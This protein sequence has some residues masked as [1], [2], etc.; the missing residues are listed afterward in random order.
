MTARP[1]TTGKDE[2]MSITT[3]RSAFLALTVA[4]SAG[5]H[6]ALVPEHLEEMPRLGY[7]F[8]VAAVTGGLLACGLVL[9]SHDRRVAF[10]AGLF[11]LG[12]ISAWALFVSIPVPGF[13]G[14]PEPVEAIAL[15]CKAVEVVGVVVALSLAAPQRGRLRLSPA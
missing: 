5:L 3:R 7:A 15:V 10:L 12:Q 9:R 4:F 2:K 1:P 6:A 14:T 11:C 13:A 8:I